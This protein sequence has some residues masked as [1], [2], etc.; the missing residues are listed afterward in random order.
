MTHV[1]DAQKSGLYRWE[2]KMIAPHDKSLVNPTH[3]QVIVDHV[4][5]EVGLQYP[6]KVKVLPKQN[7][8]CWADAT[9]TEIR[10]QSAG[11]PTWVLLHELAHSMTSDSE[12]HSHR[13]GPVF[14]ATYIKLVCKY[15]PGINRLVL[16][17]SLKDY[18]LITKG[19][20]YA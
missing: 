14:L 5:A 6:P 9:R 4:W 10:V 8:S 15:I 12:G 19:D 2:R 1:R 20:V 16:L 13:H 11:I 18:N 7:K 17:A 3:L